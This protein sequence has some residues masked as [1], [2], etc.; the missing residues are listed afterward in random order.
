MKEP[1]NLSREVFINEGDVWAQ[2]APSVMTTSSLGDLEWRA[3]SDKAVREITLRSE[4]E[5]AS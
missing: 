4:S 5:T 1:K 2:C 3:E